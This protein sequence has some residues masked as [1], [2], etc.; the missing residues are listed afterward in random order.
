MTQLGQSGGDALVDLFGRTKVVI[1][2]VHLSPLPGAPRYDGEAVE[3]IYQRGLDDARS[4]LDGGCDGVIVENHGDIPFAKPDDIGPETAAYMAVISDRIRREFGKPIGINVLANAAIPALAIA[5]A[6]GA[7]FIRVNQWANAYVAN[8]GFVEGESGRAARYRAKLRANGIRVFADAHVKHGAHAIVADRPVEELVKDLVF[9]DA[10]AIIATGQR[11][12]HAADL[13]YISMIKEAAGLPTLVGSG[14]T[15][16][17]ANDILGI[18][19]GIIIASA[20]KHDG[21][22]WNQVDPARVKT[23]I[24][25]LRR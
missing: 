5:S 15:P 8:E 10:D 22:W 13:S 1:G 2:V 17:N 4:Y 14:V 23:F 24:R 3:A 6:S 12:G 16:D 25:G 11:T 19:D 18:V 20:L 21:V 7:G 9:F